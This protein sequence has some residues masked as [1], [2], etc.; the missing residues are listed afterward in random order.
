VASAAW[1]LNTREKPGGADTS[2]ASP[3]TTCEGPGSTD[4]SVV[5][6]LTTTC[7]EP[8]AD[9][10]IP[11]L[12]LAC[13]TPVAA[14]ISTVSRALLSTTVRGRCATAVAAEGAL[15]DTSG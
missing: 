10:A 4:A 7:E 5:W 11:V 14:C 6:S 9:T 8:G 3:L 2:A 15:M 13:D 12:V 1:L